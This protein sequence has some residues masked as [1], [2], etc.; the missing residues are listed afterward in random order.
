MR[1]VSAM[2]EAEM[3]IIGSSRSLSA[4]DSSTAANVRQPWEFQSRMPVLAD[5]LARLLIKVL[6]MPAENVRG[7]DRQRAVHVDRAR[8]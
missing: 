7:V 5:E 2:P 8:A 1:P 3:M 4:L 6:R